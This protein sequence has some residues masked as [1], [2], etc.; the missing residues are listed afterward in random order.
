MNLAQNGFHVGYIFQ[1]FP[2][3]YV[4]C[5]AIIKFNNVHILMCYPMGENS[6]QLTAFGAEGGEDRISAVL[7]SGI[8][9]SVRNLKQHP[10]WMLQP[11]SAQVTHDNGAYSSH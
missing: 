4:G 2:P 6:R 10:L 3:R 5:Q 11:T 9:R 1:S 7:E 8:K